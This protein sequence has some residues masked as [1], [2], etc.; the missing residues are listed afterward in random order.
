MRAPAFSQSAARISST[1]ASRPGPPKTQLAGLPSA[2][3]SAG[4]PSSAD[5][6]ASPRWNPWSVNRPRSPA[7]LPPLSSLAS[8]PL[9]RAIFSQTSFMPGGSAPSWCRRSGPRPRWARTFARDRIAC[10]SVV[11]RGATRG[12][13]AFGPGHVTDPQGHDPHVGLHEARHHV[14]LDLV[15]VEVRLLGRL[16]LSRR[17]PG[18]NRVRHLAR[19]LVRTG[20]R[21]IG[22]FPGPQRHRRG[23]AARDE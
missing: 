14:P 15:T 1:S 11:I 23:E 9:L 10:A 17:H 18:R 19:W 21:I 8:P 22:A 7:C 2:A 5:R 13:P 6:A 3:G 4:S 20:A 16:A 12:Q